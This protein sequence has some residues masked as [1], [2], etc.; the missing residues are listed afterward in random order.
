M[1]KRTETTPVQSRTRSLSAVA[2]AVAAEPC[3]CNA[4]RIRCAR[5]RVAERNARVRRPSKRQ[6]LVAKENR[7]GLRHFSLK[8]CEKVQEKNQ[9]TYAEVADE[10]VAQISAQNRITSPRD[11]PAPVRPSLDHA[12][13]LFGQLTAPPA[14]L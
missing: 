6:R 3:V 7:S 4:P 11:A 9:T 12:E 13:L 14:G 10:L 2:A 1:P 5:L 8:V